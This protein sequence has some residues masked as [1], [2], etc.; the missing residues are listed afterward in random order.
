LYSKIIRFSYL[1][2]GEE[3][4]W[5]QVLNIRTKLPS[6]THKLFTTLLTKGAFCGATHLQS[7]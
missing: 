7:K 3:V 6:S 5:Q 4:S 1:I 2:V